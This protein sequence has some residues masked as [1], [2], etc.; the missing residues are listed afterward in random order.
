M[1]DQLVP[2]K[3][4]GLAEA[5]AELEAVCDEIDNH[6]GVLTEEML[7]R[8]N[9]AELSL[10]H[11]VDCW[12]NYVDGAKALVAHLKDRKERATKAYRAAQNLE[13]RL[14]G[15][16]CLQLQSRPGIPFKG[17]KEGSLVLCKNSQL[18]L[19]IAYEADERTHPETLAIRD[20]TVYDVVPDELLMIEPS[21]SNYVKERAFKTLNKELLREDLKNGL[22]L[23]WARTEQGHHVRIRT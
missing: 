19:W 13:S 2:I 18:K 20:K 16:L 8:F 3:R 6:D 11:R 14:R 21:M 10:A 15:F 12:I 17:E 22:Q 1:P 5:A 9:H 4:G 7:A 23:G